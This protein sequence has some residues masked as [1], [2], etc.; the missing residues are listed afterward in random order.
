MSEVLYSKVYQNKDARIDTQF[1]TTKLFYSPKLK[2]ELIGN[3]LTNS[4][5]GISLEMNEESVGVPIYRM[6]EIHNMLCDLDVDKYADVTPTEKQT[7][8][9][10]EGDVLFN[11]TNSY[12]WVGRT[13]IYKKQKDKEHIFASYLVKFNPDKNQVLPEYLTTYLNSKFGVTDVK[14]RAR[15]SIN[16]T[17][18]NPEEV[19]ESLIPLLKM[20]L[21]KKIKACFDSAFESTLQSQAT[22]T[23][24]EQ[25]LLQAIGLNNFKPTT[26][27]TNPKKL[28]E[29]FALSGRLD[30][31]YYM[32]KYEE[33][34][35]KITESKGGADI[36][37]NCIEYL[38]TG[39]FFE[40]V[41]QKRDGY[42]PYII[43]T[44]IKQLEILSDDSS[45][46]DPKN[47][48]RF[49]QQG[50][51]LTGRVGAVGN[52]GVVQNENTGN[53]CSDNII[54]FKLK[55]GFDPLVYGMFLNTDLSKLQIEKISGGSVQPLVTQTSIK[56][57]LLP[58]IESKTQQQ[59]SALIQQSFALKKQ[60]KEL[61]AKAKLAV[62]VAIEEGEERGM[63][64]LNP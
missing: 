36:L 7:F 60:S 14:R 17:N 25:L 26:K 19:K 30:A 29:S 13:G 56:A 3:I 12:E 21:Q 2:Y 24:A 63:E 8:L 50:E 6:N 18:I 39:E 38:Y 48:F 49:L 51:I 41:E 55:K 44:F 34:E 64:I 11:R 23:Q 43:N 22:Y 62:E 59:I 32:P 54:G 47:H 53:V 52:F 4:Q 40:K 58:L 20:D 57:L 46:V 42:V 5:Y 33:V 31:E 61:L 10:Y 28:S 45:Y 37:A 27:N 1:H 16:Q 9:L 15:Q 35:K